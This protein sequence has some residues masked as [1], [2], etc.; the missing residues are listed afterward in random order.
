MAEERREGEY[1]QRFAEWCAD[2]DATADPDFYAW[3][4]FLCD[5]QLAAAHRRAKDAGMRTG[6]IT[7][8][9]VGVHPAGADAAILSEVLAPD[10]TVGAPPDP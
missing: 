2:F 4:Q 9:A 8:L 10:V 5:E 1:L 7:D 6:L 3:L